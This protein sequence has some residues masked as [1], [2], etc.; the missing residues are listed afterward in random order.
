MRLLVKVAGVDNLVM[1]FSKSATIGDIIPQ[2]EQMASDLRDDGQKVK[3]KGLRSTQGV[4]MKSAFLHELLSDGGQVEAV[5]AGTPFPSSTSTTSVSDVI[6]SIPPISQT[7]TKYYGGIGFKIELHYSGCTYKWSLDISRG[8]GCGDSMYDWTDT[9]TISGTFMRLGD[10]LIL[11][12][13]GE[14]YEQRGYGNEGTRG[15]ELNDVTL[16]PYDAI[17]VWGNT[18]QPTNEGFG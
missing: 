12:K 3:I 7:G 2:I 11:T 13:T 15:R 6:Q 10:K 14:E 17:Q 18:Y 9:Q 1:V 5:L 4:L 16:L 8:G